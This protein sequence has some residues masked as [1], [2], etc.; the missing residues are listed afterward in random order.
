MCDCLLSYYYYYEKDFVLR[1]IGQLFPGVEPTVLDS[2]RALSIILRIVPR[3]C[4][5]L[6]NR[7]LVRF[8][9]DT[10]G[11]LVKGLIAGKITHVTE[12]QH[13]ENMKTKIMKINLQTRGQLTGLSGKPYDFYKQICTFECS[14]NSTFDECTTM[15]IKNEQYCS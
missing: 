3:C 15:V 9:Y 5:Y 13:I 6:P 2:G 7:Q 1:R 11:D 14:S 8:N 12:D 10:L 4:A